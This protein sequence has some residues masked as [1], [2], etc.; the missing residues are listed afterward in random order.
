MAIGQP[1]KKPTPVELNPEVLGRY[2]GVYQISASEE[3]RIVREDSRL[4]S[5]RGQGPRMEIVPFSSNEFFFRDSMF[6]RLTFISDKDGGIAA[7]EMHRRS[8]MPEIAMR[9]EKR[10]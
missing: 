4:F 3:R 6:S 7:V 10:L 9:V 2:E 5:Y 1:Y 8:G